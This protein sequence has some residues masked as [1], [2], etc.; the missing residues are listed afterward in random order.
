MLYP[1]ITCDNPDITNCCHNH[2]LSFSQSSTLLCHL[3]HSCVDFKRPDA[4]HWLLGLTLKLLKLQKH[5]ESWKGITQEEFSEHHERCEET[6]LFDLFCLKKSPLPLLAHHQLQLP[7]LKLLPP[8]VF[9]VGSLP[10]ASFIQV[11]SSSSLS[12][13][14]SKTAPEPAITYC[15]R[16]CSLTN[17]TFS[18]LIVITYLD[19]CYLSLSCPQSHSFLC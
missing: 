15:P 8:Y 14:L 18:P 16:S 3:Q 7:L 10:F 12:S 5:L 17:S 11:S 13:P 19:M 4:A 1:D 6:E 9:M 2:D